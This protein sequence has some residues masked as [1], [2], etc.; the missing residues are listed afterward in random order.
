MRILPARC[1]ILPPFIDG[2]PG[3]DEFTHCAGVA[4]RW[5]PVRDEFVVTLLDGRDIEF[6]A[7]RLRWLDDEAA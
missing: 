7:E 6:H 3:D 2:A 1:V 4:K 5:L